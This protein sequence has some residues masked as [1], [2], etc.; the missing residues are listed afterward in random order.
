MNSI[1]VPLSMLIKSK[2]VNSRKLSQVSAPVVWVLSAKALR[3]LWLLCSK[4]YRIWKQ[5]LCE[6][7]SMRHWD[8]VQFC[9]PNTFAC[10]SSSC[11]SAEHWDNEL[12]FTFVC[13]KLLQVST[14]VV[15]VL[16]TETLRLLS[17]LCSEN[18]RMWKQHLGECWTLRFF[19]AENC[20]MWELWLGKFWAMRHWASFYF[21]SPKTVACE[22]TSCASAD[23]SALHFNW[24]CLMIL[25]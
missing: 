7:W 3:F 19:S 20:C 24:K 12:P 15:W 4:N 17:I 10:E 23:F 22:S 9:A 11:A 18:Y 25:Q 21:C 14:P 16:S 5:Q 13:Q 6:C 2:W 1:S 8:S